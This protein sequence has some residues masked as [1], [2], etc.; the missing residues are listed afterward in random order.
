MPNDSVCR[1]F[2]RIDIE[3]IFRRSIVASFPS[4]VKIIATALD[5]LVPAT[6]E[7]PFGF[8]SFK[9]STTNVSTF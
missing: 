3:I 5:V 9:N 2:E 8:C 6:S 1:M 4:R 7:S